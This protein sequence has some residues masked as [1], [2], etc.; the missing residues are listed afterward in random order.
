VGALVPARVAPALSSHELGQPG[1]YYDE[2][3]ESAYVLLPLVDA[4]PA[5]L[6]GA[7]SLVVWTTTPWTLLSTLGGGGQPELTYAGRR[8][9]MVVA[10]PWSRMSRRGCV[11]LAAR[12][13]L[14]AGG[15]AL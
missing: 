13:R 7:T 4:D 10:K 15:P 6:S 2:T 8:R 5:A 1:V 9:R 12:G 14:G 11:H 3:D